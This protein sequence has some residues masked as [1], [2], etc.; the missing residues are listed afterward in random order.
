MNNSHNKPTRKN[1]PWTYEPPKPS[2][3]LKFTP[4]AWSKL[5][6][7]RDSGRS[8]VGGFGISA[9][10]DPL[11][12]TDVQLVQQTCTPVSVAFDDASVADY[13]D[14]QVDQGLPPSRFARLWLHTHPG[15]SAEPSATDEATFDRVFGSPD[16]VVMFILAEEGQ[17]YARLRFNVGPGGSIEISSRV[18][19]RAPFGPSEHATWDAEYQA[20]V[21]IVQRGLSARRGW[22]ADKP[23]PIPPGSTAGS[24]QGSSAEPPEDWQD[25]WDHYSD[26]DE[27]E[28]VHSAFGELP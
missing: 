7:F 26:G 4:A 8:E 23:R 13:F 27:N 24:P 2:A 15:S 22:F 21:N 25:A 6:Y 14:R 19:F 12:V 28:P 11:L 9:A 18:D 10:D 5:I 17:T 3:A 1:R 20:N 16:W